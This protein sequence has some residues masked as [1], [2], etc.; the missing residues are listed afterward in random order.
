MD[1]TKKNPLRK[2]ISSFRFNRGSNLTLR[3]AKSFT[4]ALQELKSV[5]KFVIAARP[6]PSCRP[7]NILLCCSK[8]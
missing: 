8:T 4:G 5:N 6:P 2:S 7:E 3:E 1:E